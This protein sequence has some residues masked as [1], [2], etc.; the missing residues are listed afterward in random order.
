MDKAGQLVWAPEHFSLCP[1]NLA[2]FVANCRDAVMVFNHE[3]GHT[4]LL[5]LPCT[6]LPLAPGIKSK[7]ISMAHEDPA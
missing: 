3:T 5:T 7:L 1:Y 6:W 2:V 4:A